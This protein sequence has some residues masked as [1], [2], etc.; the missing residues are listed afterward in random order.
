MEWMGA[1]APDTDSERF[2]RAADSL[3]DLISFGVAPALL[4][5]EARR[6]GAGLG[7]FARQLHLSGG[8]CHALGSRRT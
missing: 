5:Y 8:G 6:R 2:R 3:A 1:R 4:I 7:W